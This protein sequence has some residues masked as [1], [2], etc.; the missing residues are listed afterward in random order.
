MNQFVRVG[1]GTNMVGSLWKRRIGLLGVGL[2]ATVLVACGGTGD[3][4]L[5]V[6]NKKITKK[7]NF[8]IPKS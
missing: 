1:S 6:E 3:D 4:W 5:D 7:I 8:F 2:L